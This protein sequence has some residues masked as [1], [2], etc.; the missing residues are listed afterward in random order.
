MKSNRRQIPWCEGLKTFAQATVG[1]LSEAGQA[2]LAAAA[3][4]ILMPAAA[5]AGLALTLNGR[6]EG[7]VAVGPGVIRVGG[8]SVNWA[9]VI[10]VVNDLQAELPVAPEAL[11]LK[12]GEIWAGKVVKL[13]EGR[14]TLESSFGQRQIAAAD[15]CA[16][17]FMPGLPL[18]QEDDNGGLLHRLK[19]RPIPGNLISID[20]DLATIDTALGAVTL[21]KKDL[22]RYV[23]S[24]AKKKPEARSDDEL[25]LADGSILCG[26]CEPTKDGLRIKHAVLG[27]QVIQ[28]G[29]WQ[30]V[31]RHSTSVTYLAEA[32]PS[33]VKAFPVIR[34]PA[35]PPGVERARCRRPTGASPGF[36]S[37][38]HFWPKTIA[39]YK[40]PGQ[41]GGKVVFR[42]AVALAEGSRGAARVLFRLGD[43][44]VFDQVLTPENSK[45]VPVSFEAEAGS[46]LKLEVDFG[47]AV[48]FPCSVTMEDPYVV[49]K[50]K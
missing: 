18:I 49:A 17:D 34:R 24:G 12:S 48:R 15:V 28:G 8:A 10:L 40:L 32:A 20:A 33:F 13:A 1:G 4:A 26:Q 45:A 5:F 44:V 27:E 6:Q 43:R 37:R 11:H 38:V 2:V 7:A 46:D 22:K 14:I 35:D 39:D 3:L 16:I 36:V 19:G 31:R 50:Q 23:L 9:D 30:S 21:D 25:T 47:K 41:P 29:R 42:A